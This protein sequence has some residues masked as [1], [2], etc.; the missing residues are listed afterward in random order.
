MGL[1]YG[2][3][4]LWVISDHERINARPGAGEESTSAASSAAIFCEF[5]PAR[6]LNLARTVTRRDE[7]GGDGDEVHRV[8]MRPQDA[9]RE[10]PGGP[11]QRLQRQVMPAAGGV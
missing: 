4:H 8:R 10:V 3:S 6:L 7:Q 2:G 9:V 11:S 5:G 1:L